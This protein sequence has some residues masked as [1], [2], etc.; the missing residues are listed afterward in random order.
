MLAHNVLIYAPLHGKDS[1]V[2]VVEKVVVLVVA[3]V[4]P[5]PED[6]VEDPPAA[7]VEEEEEEEEEEL[8]VVSQTN[9]G[10]PSVELIFQMLESNPAGRPLP[11]FTVVATPPLLKAL[12]GT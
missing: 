2:V 7:T 6:A 10:L 3:L 5:A 9:T 12:L 11:R 8:D 1:A 4:V